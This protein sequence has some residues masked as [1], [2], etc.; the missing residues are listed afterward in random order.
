MGC[1]H[2]FFSGAYSQQMKIELNIDQ[3]F[4]MYHEQKLVQKIIEYKRSHPE[5]T[6]KIML[7]SGAFSHYQ[8]S[9]KKGIVLTDKDMYEY[10][11][12]Y[13]NFLNEWGDDLFCFVGVDTVPNPENVDPT[14]IEKTWQNYLYMYDR[15]KPSIRHKLIPVF[16]Y[17]EDFTALKRWLEYRHEDGTPV[18]YIGLAISLEGDTKERITWGR[19]CM[20]IIA[21]SSNPNVKT[22]AFGVGVKAVLEHIDV[23][24]TDATSWV[25][26]AAYGMIK[27]DDI[28]VCV[29]D[30]Q[31]EQLKGKHFTEKSLA[32]SDSIEKLVKDR[33]FRVKPVTSSYT[34]K[35]DELTFTVDGVNE[36]AYI[37]D[38]NCIKYDNEMYTLSESYEKDGKTY[39]KW[40]KDSKYFI[41]DDD[42]SLIYDNGKCLATNCYARARFNILD[43]LNW[44]KE[45]ENKKVVIT[46]KK[47]LW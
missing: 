18:D 20:R 13:I 15:L 25:K 27:I 40:Q 11:D 1:K 42:S 5:Y 43:V 36:V 37:I 39:R 30:V 41:L 14:F 31:E 7:D 2:Y 29:S 32:Y 34:L 10:T 3:L 16:H 17:G 45:M 8:N 21:A 44:L 6:A 12:K 26:C 35:N 19:E 23:T 47:E 9:L 4:S 22:H 46:S 28:S 38:E 33:G 24:S